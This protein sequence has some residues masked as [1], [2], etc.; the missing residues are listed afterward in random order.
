MTNLKGRKRTMLR[1]Y[2]KQLVLGTVS[3]AILMASSF[4]GHADDKHFPDHP[5]HGKKTNINLAA[6]SNF[7]GVPPSNSAIT[8]IINAFMADNPNYTVTVVDNGA[9]ATLESHIINGNTARV[10]L[11]L[12]ADTGC[13]WRCLRSQ[14]WVV[15]WRHRP[16]RRPRLGCRGAPGG[17]SCLA[18]NCAVGR[19]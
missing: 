13:L 19:R 5:S 17:L 8:D 15:R 18:G 9:T 3:A 7:Y 10:D 14:L 2:T 12:A 11:F 1:G 4:V 6:A 16:G